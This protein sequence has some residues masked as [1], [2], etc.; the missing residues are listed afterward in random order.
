MDPKTL[1]A[2][3]SKVA[4]RFPEVAGIKPQIKRQPVP[5]ELAG[6]P[7]NYLLLYKM[8]ANGPTGKNI[9][10]IV[11]VIVSPQGKV[12]KMTTSR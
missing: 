8:Q 3:T 11:R 4:R 6:T 10:R 7:P 2:V 9:S 5:K 1:Q 12:L